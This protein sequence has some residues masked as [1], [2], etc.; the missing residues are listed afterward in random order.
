MVYRRRRQK[1][2]SNSTS[3]QSLKKMM[4]AVAF[5]TQE[6]K[7]H[8]V[9]EDEAVLDTGSVF[10]LNSV[11]SQ[12]VASGQFVGQEIRQ[13]GLRLRGSFVQADSSN[14]VRWLVLSLSSAFEIGLAAGGYNSNDIFYDPNSPLYSPMVESHISKVYLDRTVVLNQADGA[15]NKI[16]L[17]NKWISLGMRK[18]MFDETSTLS[19]KDG[20][21]K[22]FLMGFSD[23]GVS[24][25]PTIVVHSTLYYK[26]A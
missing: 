2:S 8:R 23:S 17:F 12:G 21:D 20:S 7:H 9:I 14:I 5:S 24:P 4:R 1:R 18:Y 15:N 6:T 22:I 11:D 16:S 26:D 3:K 19:P 10:E 13:I 25:H